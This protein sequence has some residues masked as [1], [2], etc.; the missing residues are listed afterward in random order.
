MKVLYTLK[1]NGL[2]AFYA[3]EKWEGA[4]NN[5]VITP[6]ALFARANDAVKLSGYLNVP[7]AARYKFCLQLTDFWQLS[8]T[9]D[10]T[11]IMWQGTKSK[12]NCISRA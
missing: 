10:T 1:N 3:G 7:A 12:K 11:G 5:E 6:A 8:L 2:R 4:V 9:A